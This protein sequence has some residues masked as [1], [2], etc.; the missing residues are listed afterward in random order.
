MTARTVFIHA[1]T[2]LHPGTGQG[3]GV[4]DLPIA[5]EAATGIPYLPG[6]SLKGV[7]RDRAQAN[8]DRI[9]GPEAGSI[10]DANARAGAVMFSDQR[11]L[12]FPARSLAGTMAWVTSPFIL[13]RFR[14]D[15]V[16]L[17]GGA[18]PDAPANPDKQAALVAAETDLLISGARRMVVLEDID[19][20]PQPD[21]EEGD[22]VGAW[23]AWLGA[24]LFPDEPDW[25]ESLARRL[26]IVHDDI[27]SFL[28]DTATEVIARNQLTDDKTSGN[29]WYEEALPAESILAG[30][31]L[32][33]QVGPDGMAPAAV[34]DEVATL[35]ATPVQLGGH[36]TIGRGICRVIIG[37]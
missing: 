7:L 28:L 37:G 20:T 11:L 6:S 5:R 21:D 12:L 33:Q 19:L 2:S 36:A 23:A 4:I 1:Y 15:C 3:A 8:V 18:P 16:R 25:Q 22:T 26:C 29:L 9:F 13:Q 17:G 31:V 30:L 24:R 14:R 10:T 35:V 27:L 34:L 32:A